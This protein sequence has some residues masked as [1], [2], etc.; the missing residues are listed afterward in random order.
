MACSFVFSICSNPE[1]V[2]VAATILPVLS[3]QTSSDG[4][5]F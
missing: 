3:V 4:N 5:V 1:S 2:V